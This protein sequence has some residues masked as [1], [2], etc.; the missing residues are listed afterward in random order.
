MT[1]PIHGLVTGV[2]EQILG[3]TLTTAIVAGD[4][5]LHVQDV[6]DFDEDGG[7]LRFPD[8]YVPSTTLPV[9]VPYATVDD[10]ASTITLTAPIAFGVSAPVDTTVEVYDFANSQPA[11]TYKAIVDS[12]DGFDG[13]PVEATVDQGLAHALAQEMRDGKGE[14]VTLERDGSELRLTKI[15]GRRFALAAEQ[16]LQGGMT[17]RQNDG[18][19]GVD[20]TGADSRTPGVFTYTT[21]GVQTAFMDE[22]GVQAGDPSGQRVLM[23][24][25]ATFGGGLVQFLNGATLQGQISSWSSGSTS[26]ARLSGQRQVILG[27]DHDTTN[28]IALWLS[29]SPVDTF[30]V[31]LRALSGVQ[32]QAGT[33]TLDTSATQAI[34]RCEIHSTANGIFM[35]DL[36]GGGVT[37]A[38]IN[39]NGRVIRTPSSR[40]YK[41]NV[42]PLPI[43]QARKVL[44][45]E[46]VT[47]T[48][49]AE[50]KDK[51]R[52]TYPGFIAEQAAE[53]GCDLWVNRDAEGEPD[54]F[55]YAELVAALIPIIREQQA[56]LARLE[57]CVAD[58]RRAD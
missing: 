8:V 50:A 55:R 19:A 53:A 9:V 48:L 21:N 14:S 45:L 10:D 2:R 7:W 11:V 47:F 39:T 17:T 36:S 26:G 16:Y 15:H 32:I 43:D 58:L 6:C 12:L 28:T 57:Q 29:D 56:A 20:I 52:R 37:A 51:G 42:K 44:D 13:D 34:F 49:K 35:D 40:R 4:T 30:D 5:V 24:H 33:G 54:G 31:N 27:V 38:S 3:D 41:S 25:D 18:D 1:D 23:T 46:P 22:D